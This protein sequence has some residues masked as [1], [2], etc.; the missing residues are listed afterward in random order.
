MDLR[1]RV[2]PVHE[3][4]EGALGV[5]VA[6]KGEQEI[7]CG[8]LGDVP[9]AYAGFKER[10]G[11]EIVKVGV[12]FGQGIVVVAQNLFIEYYFQTTHY[13]FLPDITSK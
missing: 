4:Y 3:V 1:I 8:S 11:R 5:L 9:V 7:I 10:A 13:Y 6:F 12:V 2:A